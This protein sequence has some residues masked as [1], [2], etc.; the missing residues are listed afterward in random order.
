MVPRYRAK[1]ER[2]RTDDRDGKRR[3]TRRERR[4]AKAIGN[5]RSIATGKRWT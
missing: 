3:K 4:G 5:W 1:R 2:N